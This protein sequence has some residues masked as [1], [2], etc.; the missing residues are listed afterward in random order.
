MLRNRIMLTAGFLLSS[1][2]FAQFDPQGS[3]V[4]SYFPQLADG[5][6]PAQ[7]WITSFTFLNPNATATENGQVNLYD[8]SGNPLPIDFGNGP[9]SSFN[10]ATPPNG[11]VVFKSTGSSPSIVTGWAIVV[12]TLPLQ[13]VVQYAF[14]V[15]GIPQQGVSSEATEASGL[16]RSPATNVTGIAIANVYTN[17]ITVNVALLDSNGASVTNTSIPLNPVG[18][19]SFTV[20]QL[21]PTLQ[22]NFRG[23]VLIGANAPYIAAPSSYCVA[24]T[25]SS[26]LGVLASYP[27][28][29]LGWPVSQYERIW[30]V[31]TKILNAAQLANYP[32]S[33]N[34]PQ[35]F[36]D[37]TTGQINSFASPSTNQVHIFINLAELVSDSES[38]L[39]FAVAHELGHIIQARLG[40]F[41]FVPTNIEQDAD[42]YGVYLSLAAGYDPYAGA[43]TLAKLAMASGSAGLV[44]QNFDQLEAFDGG[45]LHGSFNDRL[46]AMFQLMQLACGSSS[47]AETFCTLYKS[48]VHP[49]LP[50]QAPLTIPSPQQ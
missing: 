48:D 50:A 21:F 5:G 10:F 34:P 4:I 27:P 18:H 35:L 31:W 16:F 32:V 1:Q 22:A 14:S 12:S 19:S 24:W 47:S 41:Q 33:V 23:T 46:A 39:A 40:A 42:K 17:P 7:K 11:S 37:A 2:L 43:G 29:G 26:D 13:G 28:S 3:Q 36:I 8:N 45:D 25:L 20:Q 6:T 9:V 15:N 44:S 30:K 49:H 38:E